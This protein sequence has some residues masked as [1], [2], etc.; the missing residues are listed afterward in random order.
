MRKSKSN[1][2]VTAQQI[3]LLQIARRELGM[4]EQDYRNTL[5]I[6]GGVASSKQL[7][8]AGFERIMA[9]LKALGF[10]PQLKPR[11]KTRHYPDE[12]PSVMQNQRILEL[13][14]SLGWDAKRYQGF[15]KKR[16][17]SLWPKTRE[18]AQK[19][20]ETLKGMEGRGY[21]ERIGN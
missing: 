13:Y 11:A 17:Q 1:S 9:R 15:H 14:K 20:I 7:D 12:P 2:Q 6:Y 4:E 3:K 16:F 18:E 5:G 19:L 21:G 8:Q 10:T